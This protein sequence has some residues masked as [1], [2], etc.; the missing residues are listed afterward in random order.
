MRRTVFVLLFT[1]L[2]ASAANWTEYRIGP[3]RVA[4]DA[5]DKSARDRLN[6]MEQLRYE[7]GTL[8]GKDTLAVGGPSATR[9]QLQTVWPID[10]ILFSN[11]KEYA[12]HALGKPFIEGGSS[13]LS[14]WTGDTPLLRDFLRELARMLIDENSGVMPESIETGLCDLLSTLKAAGPRLQL[15]ALPTEL[16]SDRLRGWAKIQMLATQPD[17]SGK[18]RVYLN[19]L[20]GIG[21][22]ALAAQNAY[23]MTVAKLNQAAD[24]YAHAGNFHATTVSGEAL[25]PSRD[26]IEK[27]LDQKSV[28]DL[29]AELA[30]GGKHFP[31]ESPRGLLAKGTRPALELAAVANPRW[32]EPHFL[33]AP[34]ESNEDDRIKQ[35]KMAATFDPHNVEYWEALAKAQTLANQYADAEKSWASALKAAPNETERAS[36]RQVRIDLAEKRAEYEAAEKKRI[37]EEQARELQRL[38]DQSAA[39]IHA[40]EVAINR[41][42]GPL[43]PADKPVQWWGDPP[44]EKVSGTLARIDCLAGGAMR[45]TIRIDGG[46]TIRLLVRDPNRLE[47]KGTGEARFNCGGQRTGRKIRAIYSVKTD[48]KLNT[49][50]EIAMVEFPE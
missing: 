24:A 21:D 38:K 46:G 26:F 45:L 32:A 5:G 14:A 31:P 2:S 11:Q 15:G 39:E 25:D 9:S 23:G 37:A 18:F 28:D 6:E 17:Y 19:N 41:K 35:L 47:V 40:A 27:P 36:I 49:V 48:A 34:L 8:L 44:G 4:S 3:F 20:Q 33:L 1:A 29:L 7:L 50:G 42:L 13:M 43:N 12:P 16:P 10:V 30:A 22:E